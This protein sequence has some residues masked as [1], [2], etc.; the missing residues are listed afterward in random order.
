MSYCAIIAGIRFPPNSEKEAEHAKSGAGMVASGYHGR[1]VE[2]QHLVPGRKWCRRSGCKAK[3][4]FFDVHLMC[5]KPEILLKP[6]V[7]AGADSDDHP[8]GTG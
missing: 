2:A 8:C 4:M 1:P 7:E 3:K 6:F 5:G